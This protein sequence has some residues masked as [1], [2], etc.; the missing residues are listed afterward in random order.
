MN[1]VVLAL[2]A[3]VVAAS[4]KAGRGGAPAASDQGLVVT[5]AQGQLRG[6]ILRSRLGK[7]I[8]SFRGVRFAEPPLGELRFKAPVPVSP[9]TGVR[10]ATED[11][12]ACFQPVAEYPVPMSEDCLFLN[13]YTTKL[14]RGNSNPRRPVVVFF[15]PGGF[16]SFTGHSA[17]LGPQYLLDHEL[18]LVT[19]NYRLGALGLLS[20]DDSV[21]PGNYAMKDQ[22]AVLRWV[23]DNIAAFGGD[24][25]AVTIAGYSAGAMSVMMHMVSPMARGL[26]SKGISMS[27]SAFFSWAVERNPLP[28]AQ[29][30][31]LNFNCSIESSESIRSCLLLQDAQ[32]IALALGI[33]RE[34][35]WDPIV[36]FLPVLERESDGGEQYL[37]EDPIQQMLS[38]NFAQVPFI[39]GMTQDEF[40]WRSLDVLRNDTWTEEINK[41]YERVYPIAFI[42]ERGTERSRN[43]TGEL[44][45]FYL[46]DMDVEN[47]TS[48]GLGPMYSDG[49]VGFG[50]HR[51]S[52]I[53]P[54]VNSKP[55]Y[56]YKFSF[57]GRYSYAYLPGTTTPFGVSHHDET[58][59]LFYISVLAPFFTENDPEIVMVKRLTKLWANFIQ[60]GPWIVSGHDGG[61]L[62]GDPCRVRSGVILLESRPEMKADV[63]VRYRRL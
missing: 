23:R 41:E 28:L 4:S 3:A 27:G 26:F 59:Y 36:S 32:Q 47:T 10:N 57:P 43:I 37:T 39:T 22:V 44:R 2:L 1:A 21:L 48:N 35:A 29:K 11:G 9:W 5:T 40:A 25:H 15:N 45:S 19:S 42:Y 20:T 12:T 38:G 8:F 14:P 58:L 60:T 52:K 33:Y 63:D 6:S 50:V 13:V 31:A 46:H 17:I 56:Y 55:V 18:I 49:L 34:F 7:D 30:M 51:T 54:C 53:L 61:S 16:Y 62:L 24:P